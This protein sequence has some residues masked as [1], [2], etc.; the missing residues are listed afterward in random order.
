MV[1]VRVPLSGPAP[2]AMAIVSDTPDS[3]TAAP[4]EFCS[5][6]LTVKFDPRVIDPLGTT[7][8][9]TI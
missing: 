6:T 5:C 9:T 3:A 8:T 1:R 4:A 2:E 7:L